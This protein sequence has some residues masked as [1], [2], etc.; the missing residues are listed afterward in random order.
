MAKD[1]K[2]NA[3]TRR[4]AKARQHAFR[5]RRMERTASALGLEVHTRVRLRVRPRPS[6]RPS[7][8]E[9]VRAGP[10]EIHEGSAAGHLRAA[11]PLTAARPL[12]R[13][14]LGSFRRPMRRPIP[15]FSKQ[16]QITKEESRAWLTRRK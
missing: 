5:M 16:D 3:R 12:P 2:S 14:S 15:V 7:G 4:Y 9:A 10:Q 6:S 13:K 11:A 1:E 8:Q